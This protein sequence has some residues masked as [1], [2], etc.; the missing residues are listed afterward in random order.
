[1]WRSPGSR[2]QSIP[3]KLKSATRLLGISYFNLGDRNARGAMHGP[4][5]ECPA[6]CIIL[7]FAISLALV[8][9][10]LKFIIYPVV[11]SPGNI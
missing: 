7:A 4:V 1:M 8:G 6:L 11:E 3:Q 5:D 9:L 10:A 2:Q